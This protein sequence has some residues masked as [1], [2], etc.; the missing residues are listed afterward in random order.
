MPADIFSEDIIKTVDSIYIKHSSFDALENEKISREA[1]EEYYNARFF[2]QAVYRVDDE[3][4]EIVQICSLLNELIEETDEKNLQYM[5]NDSKQ[6]AVVVSDAK[7]VWLNLDPLDVRAQIIVFTK[8]KPLV[9]WI[10][11]DHVDIADKRYITSKGLYDFLQEE[12][13]PLPR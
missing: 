8:E 6:K 2:T 1:F 4:Q 13:P 12:Y 11:S 7:V 3:Q 10:S 9:V 5:P